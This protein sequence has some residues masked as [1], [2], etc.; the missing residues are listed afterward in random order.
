[1]GPDAVR[2]W[3]VG[4]FQRAYLVAKAEGEGFRKAY[5]AKRERVE[6]VCATPHVM[7]PCRCM[8]L[9]THSHLVRAEADLSRRQCFW[10]GC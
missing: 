4:P 10:C 5:L 7:G 1:M 6:Q 2:G 9:H 8:S 3:G